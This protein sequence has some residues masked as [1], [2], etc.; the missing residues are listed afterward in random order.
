MNLRYDVR[1][2]PADHR[3]VLPN[4]VLK[5][6]HYMGISKEEFGRRW[7][8]ADLLRTSETRLCH[9]LPPDTF[10]KWIPELA[11]FSSYTA[12]AVPG[13]SKDYEVFCAVIMMQRHEALLKINVRPNLDVVIQ[14]ALEDRNDEASQ[15][16]T[17]F[18]ETLQQLLKEAV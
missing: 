13:S 14:L 5:L 15:Y 3:V 18:I 4:S 9:Y 17:Y 16:F 7:L 10:T 2:E 8:S 11:E 1:G 12:F 6:A